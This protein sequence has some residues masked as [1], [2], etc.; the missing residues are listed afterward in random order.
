M[1]AIDT[2]VLVR[3]LVND[4]PAQADLVRKRF[5]QAEQQREVLFIPLLVVLETIWVLG[6]AYGVNRSEII[7]VLSDLLM[8]PI[9]DF[10]NRIALQG[11]LSSA[12]C[13]QF[14]LSDLLIAEVAR[15]ADCK[16]VLTFDKKA[17]KG[18]MFELLTAKN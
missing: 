12:P 9:L 15:Q 17:A 8:L 1:K 16:T 11:A 14:D 5:Q 13:N 2:N 3:F 6:F 4:D 18:V 7:E 10:E